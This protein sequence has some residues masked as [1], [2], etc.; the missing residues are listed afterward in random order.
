MNINNNMFMMSPFLAIPVKVVVIDSTNKLP[1]KFIA[2][3]SV[4]TL[5]SVLTIFRVTTK[6][7]F[8]LVFKVQDPDNSSQTIYES[9]IGTSN[10]PRVSITECLYI[11]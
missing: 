9:W 10:H 1:L 11:I 8:K 2:E 5:I 7:Y 3:F 4:R 6:S